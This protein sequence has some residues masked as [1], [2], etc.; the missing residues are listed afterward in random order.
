MIKFRYVGNKNIEARI[1]VAG[2]PG[3]GLVGKLA[4]DHLIEELKPK[5]ICE[6]YSSDFPPQ[7]N[8]K[9][10]G[11][12]MMPLAYIYYWDSGDSNRNILIFTGDAQPSTPQ[13]NYELASA[14]LRFA[15]KRG[16]T[17]VY[18]L[19]AFMT[20]QH[21]ENPKVFC[22]ATDN[23]IARRFEKI[24][25]IIMDNGTITGLN[26]ILVGL[27]RLM[28]MRGACLLGETSGYVVDAGAAKAALKVLTTALA[29]EI[30][31]NALEE[32]AKE[33]N[34]FMRKMAEEAEREEYRETKKGKEPPP[35]YIG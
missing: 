11:T 18:T 15:K 14:V 26:G 35:P 27:A 13:G 3:I 20:G 7:V 28:N 29:I 31:L 25:A 33:L 16:V 4:V 2:L 12:V 34:V 1:L 9:S 32:K 17:S 24:G 19:A 22:A 5:L 30:N 23:E 6:V 21:S 10:D 8:L